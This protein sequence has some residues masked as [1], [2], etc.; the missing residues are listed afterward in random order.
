M[1]YLKVTSRLL[2]LTILP[3]PCQVVSMR[4]QTYFRP[5][6]SDDIYPDC[7]IRVYI[8]S[9]FSTKHKFRALS[10]GPV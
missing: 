10:V 6:S 5:S 1:H 9:D 2:T 7:K 3:H 8:T 4:F